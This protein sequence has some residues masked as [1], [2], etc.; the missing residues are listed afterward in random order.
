MA[1]EILL[2]KEDLPAPDGAVTRNKQP[3][4]VWDM[5]FLP[6]DNLNILARFFDLRLFELS[7]PKNAF[8]CKE[9]D[10]DPNQSERKQLCHR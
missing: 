6:K 8:C 3:A 5:I 2:T 10:S 9:R 7:I 4:F 1:E